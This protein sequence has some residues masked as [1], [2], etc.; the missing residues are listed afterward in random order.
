MRLLGTKIEKTENI[1]FRVTPVEKQMLQDKADRAGLSLSEYLLRQGLSR[2]VTVVPHDL[3]A[4]YK[5]MSAE[6]GRL[7]NNMNQIAKHLN[8]GYSG[9]HVVQ[10]F[11]QNRIEVEDTIMKLKMLYEKKMIA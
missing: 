1:H 4:E 6:L 8:S 2:K 9:Y 7:G 3:F 10:W 5:L 11:D